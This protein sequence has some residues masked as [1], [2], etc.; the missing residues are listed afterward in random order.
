MVQLIDTA[1]GFVAIMAVLSLNVKSLTSLFKSYVDYYSANL[2]AEA[3]ALVKELLGNNLEHF[4]DNGHPWIKSINWKSLGEEFLQVDKVNVLLKYLDP[5]GKSVDPDTLKALVDLRIANLKYGFERRM[6]NLALSAGLAMCL[7][8]DINALTIW[9]TLYSDQQLRTT[10]AHSYADKALNLID[11][12]EHSAG[13]VEKTLSKEELQQ[14]TS[15]FREEMSGFL[16]D[17]SFGVGRMWDKPK[18]ASLPP[19]PHPSN[20]WKLWLYEFF[21]SFVTGILVSVGAPY[22]HDLLR[23][24]SELRKGGSSTPDAAPQKTGPQPAA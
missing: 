3:N 16:T 14:K 11:S 4:A 9:K 10:F 2:Y 6:K 17:V 12:K 15:D 20:D 1:I 18:S 21:G 23:T 7:L 19:A 8:C 13:S 5:N 22:W 24:L